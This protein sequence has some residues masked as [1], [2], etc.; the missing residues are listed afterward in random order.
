MAVMGF[1]ERR[2]RVSFHFDSSC[3]E[4]QQGMVSVIQQ[5]KEKIL[6]GSRYNGGNARMKDNQVTKLTI[7]RILTARFGSSSWLVCLDMSPEAV[8]VGNVA[9]LSIHSMFVLITIA[10]FDLHWVMA[11]FLFPLLVAFVIYNF[12][13]IL[14]RIELMVFVLFVVLESPE[15]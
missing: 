13:A 8:L 3:F 1:V 14:V 5:L 10:S 9:N 15:C 7:Y 11:L 2:F 6:R 4:W 12:V